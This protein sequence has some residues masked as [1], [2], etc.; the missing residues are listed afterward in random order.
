MREIHTINEW[1]IE[2]G[3]ALSEGDGD[4]IM[5]LQDLSDTWLQTD[6]EMKAQQALLNGALD[7]IGW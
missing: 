2:L 7:S 4:A 6:D 3:R 1:M 5:S